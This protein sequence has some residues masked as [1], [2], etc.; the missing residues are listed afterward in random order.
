MPTTLSLTTAWTLVSA[1]GEIDVEVIDGSVYF[2]DSS[3]TPVGVAQG[4]ALSSKGD[5]LNYHDYIAIWARAVTGTATIAVS[6]E[7]PSPFIPVD[8]LK[9]NQVN[10][11]SSVSDTILLAAN[12]A[13]KPG[14][15]ILNDSTAV[16]YIS[17]EGDASATNFYLAL[18]AKGNVPNVFFV[19]D[20]FKGDIHG[21]WASA[22]GFARVSEMT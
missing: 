19:P 2:L 1:S 5:E 22:N 11:P 17:L 13:R 20:G 18:D 9:V 3:T 14:S 21:V 12:P 4:Q 6:Q 15:V 16:L 7:D 10:V 8:L